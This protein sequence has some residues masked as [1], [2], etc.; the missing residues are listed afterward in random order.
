MGLGDLFPEE[1]KAEFASRNIEIGTVLR[2]TVKDTSPPKIKRF[3]VVGK[4]LDGLSLASVYI[5]SEINK[6]VN[7]CVEMQNLQ[8]PTNHEENEFLDKDSYIDCSKLIPRDSLEISEVIK[9]NPASVIGKLK[10]EDLDYLVET[11]RNAPTIKGKHK[12]KY[13]F[14]S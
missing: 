5:N 6:K 13:G 2:L 12:K 9:E 1:F 14:F 10:K 4:T 7:W 3:I 8:I 11:I